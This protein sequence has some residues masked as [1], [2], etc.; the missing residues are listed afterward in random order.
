MHAE[1]DTT[2]TPTAT[3]RALDDGAV[4]TWWSITRLV[5]VAG[6]DAC[7]FLDGLVTQDVADTEVG[8]ARYGLFLTAKAKIIA[9]AILH[10]TSAEAVL[11]EVLPDHVPIVIDHLRRF[12]LRA[13]V[14]VSESQRASV[15]I[16]GAK[17]AEVADAIA[18]ASDA[19]L[20]RTTSR[21]WGFPTESF[22]V[23]RASCPALI[24][25]ARAAGAGP[26]DGEALDAARIEADTPGLMEFT[27]GFMPAEVGAVETAVDFK[28][29]CYLGQEP[30]ARLHWRGHPNRTLRR[31]E[32]T[33][34]IP[35]DH[36]PIGPEAA[37]AAGERPDL[38]W[39]EL[40]DPQSAKN[41]VGWL[42]SWAHA[43]A[44]STPGYAILRCL[45]QESAELRLADTS[46]IVRVVSPAPQ[47]VTR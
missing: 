33:E 41:P 14:E 9:P 26:A 38:S 37:P 22:L 30:V 4:C 7:S 12:R 39:L 23:D 28:K 46:M 24:D 10:R 35:A 42:V 3:R 21:I 17:A 20:L 25:A 45:V 19:A 29:G 18:V 8:T 34:S 27:A 15:C 11:L 32:L 47:R 43:G 1:T 36:R 13:K 2:L 16:V 44:R 31:V 40:N 6:P 5:E